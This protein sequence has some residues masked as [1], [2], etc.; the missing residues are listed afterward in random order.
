MPYE[1]RFVKGNGPGL[2]SFLH[3]VAKRRGVNILLETKAVKLL[4]DDLGVI[5]GVRARTAKE[6]IDFR[7]TLSY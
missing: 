3:G 2:C 7:P 1:G 4:T 5:T 6:V